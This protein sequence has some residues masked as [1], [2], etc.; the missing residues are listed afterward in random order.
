MT[1]ASR[2][3]TCIGK[4]SL[5]DSTLQDELRIVERALVRLSTGWFQGDFEGVTQFGPCYCLMGAV[6]VT[7]AELD[8]GGRVI[9][10][11]EAHAGV[12]TYPELTPGVALEEWNDQEGRRY[13]DVDN[14][15]RKVRSDILKEMGS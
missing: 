2:R 1:I 11:L 5:S 8:P 15:L 14:L 9:E 10:R 4:V 6:A 7:V 3:A 12:K 13:R